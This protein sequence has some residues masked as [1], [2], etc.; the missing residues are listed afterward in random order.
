[1]C[2]ISQSNIEYYHLQLRAYIQNGLRTVVVDEDGTDEIR[3]FVQVNDGAVDDNDDFDGEDDD[4]DD[5]D[6][7]EEGFENNNLSVFG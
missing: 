6:N 7:D 1:M 4:E 5:D 2:G 3:G